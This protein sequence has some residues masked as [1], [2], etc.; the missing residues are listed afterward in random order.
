MVG[1]VATSKRSPVLL[2][3]YAFMLILAFLVLLAGVACSVKVI[4]TIH[5]GVNHSLAMPSIKTYGSDSF[6]TQSWDKLH[7]KA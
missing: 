6:A 7:R 5:V 3:F 4:F 2:H 1:L